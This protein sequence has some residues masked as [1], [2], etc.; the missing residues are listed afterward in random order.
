[1][2]QP[3]GKKPQVLVVED[4]ASLARFLQLE[5]EHEDYAVEIVKDGYN[6]VTRATECEWDLILLDVI[7]PGQD[8]F[9]VCRRIRA[10]SNVPIIMITARDTLGDRV[11][12]LDSGANDYVCKPFAVEELLARIRVQLRRLP[13]YGRTNLS[14]GDLVIDRESRTVQR[15]EESISLTRREFDLLWYLAENIGVV[16]ERETILSRVWGYDYM[17]N[18]NV[19]DVYIRYL[20]AKVDDPFP[21]KLIHTVRGVGYVMREEHHDVD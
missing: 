21:E 10:A 12:G 6:A 18:T 13:G 15:G 17:G 16:L 3:G 11:K 9:A 7:I 5:L 14:V 2:E 19:V 20:R 1:M 8:G 4:N